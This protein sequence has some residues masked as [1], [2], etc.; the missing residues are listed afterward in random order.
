MFDGS[1]KQAI[2]LFSL[3]TEMFPEDPN[4]WDSLGEAY[5][6]NGDRDKALEYYKKALSVDPYFPSAQKMIREIEKK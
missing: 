5:L 1:L 6:K 3:N 2:E 4:V